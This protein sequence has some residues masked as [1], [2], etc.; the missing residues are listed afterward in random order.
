M[1]VYE[2]DELAKREDVIVKYKKL[3]DL[4]SD[5]NGSGIKGAELCK[6]LIFIKDLMQIQEIRCARTALVMPN[7]QVT[8]KK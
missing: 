2:I 7:V 4:L 6:K 1:F 3:E 5:E 8:Q